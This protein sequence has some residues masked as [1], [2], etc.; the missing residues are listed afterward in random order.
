M[1]AVG[2]GASSLAR[3]ASAQISCHGDAAPALAAIKVKRPQRD[4][5]FQI[6]FPPRL[7][8]AF[9]IVPASCNLSPWQQPAVL[10]NYGRLWVRYIFFPPAAQE[11]GGS[12]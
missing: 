6:N 8:P 11:P 2:G 3:A 1:K 9:L 5:E 4:S 10:T 7:M 12:I